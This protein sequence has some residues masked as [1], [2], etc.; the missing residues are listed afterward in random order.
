[1]RL[2]GNAASATRSAE[3]TD[4]A[5]FWRGNVEV[6]WFQVVQKVGEKDGDDGWD[7]DDGWMDGWS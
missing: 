5:N 7:D 6:Y 2:I 1:V 4:I 3:Q